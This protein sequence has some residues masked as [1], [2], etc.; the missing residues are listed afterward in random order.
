MLEA[1]IPTL[2]DEASEGHRLEVLA[3]WVPPGVTGKA[4]SERVVAELE[5]Y[6]PGIGGLVKS[7]RC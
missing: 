7:T 3:Q 6:A 1:T 2:G 4:V 5:R